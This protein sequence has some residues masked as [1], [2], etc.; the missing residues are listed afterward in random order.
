MRKTF[1]LPTRT[2]TRELLQKPVF[3]SDPGGDHYNGRRFFNPWIRDS[4]DFAELSDMDQLIGFFTDDP[5]S[6]GIPNGIPLLHNLK[7]RA[8]PE[9]RRVNQDLHVERVWKSGDSVAQ[10]ARVGR[11]ALAPIDAP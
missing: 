1:V 2:V 8:A 11:L 6:L 4:R 3:E 5:V 10:P 9:R 7:L